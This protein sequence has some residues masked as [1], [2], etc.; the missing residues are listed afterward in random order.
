MPVA[1]K[2][3]T[4]AD[5]SRPYTYTPLMFQGM[6]VFSTGRC[7]KCDDLHRIASEKE[8]EQRERRSRLAK[9][10]LADLPFKDTEESLLP[11]QRS[12]CVLRW[13]Y[14][15]KGMF[16]HGPSGMGKTRSTLLRAKRLWIDDGKA[17]EFVNWAVWQAALDKAH[18]YGSA[19]MAAEITRL[20]KWPLLVLDDVGKGKPSVHVVTA[21][22]QV[23][24]YRTSRGL[25]TAITTKYELKRA[26]GSPFERKLAEG[27]PD[28]AKDVCRRL[29]DFSVNHPFLE[30]NKTK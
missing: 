12:R 25:P 22:F 9:W 4:C 26:E 7:P 16:C 18:R 1:T 19:G 27:S 3:A 21:F 10:E 6:E 30:E 23:I 14:G 5:C 8:A 2:Q 11:H 24:D 17:F 28:G 20:Y 13:P 15:P 29:C